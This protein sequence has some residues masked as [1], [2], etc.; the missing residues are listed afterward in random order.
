MGS[1]TRPGLRRTRKFPS[2]SKLA[3]E[4]RRIG[5]LL[6]SSPCPHT[7][8]MRYICSDAVLV[9]ARA[10]IAEKLGYRITDS[11]LWNVQLRLML[12]VYQFSPPKWRWIQGGKR[13]VAIQRAEDMIV[14]RV[15]TRVLRFVWDPHRYELS[16]A[17]GRGRGV[18]QAL[19]ALRRQIETAYTDD[20]FGAHYREA[21]VFVLHADIRHAFEE[22]EHELVME[23]LNLIVADENVLAVVRSYLH[24]VQT[25][26]NRG[27]GQGTYLAPIL[28]DIS[29][30]AIDREIASGRSFATEALPP[31][32][33]GVYTINK[34]PPRLCHEDG[35][36]AAPTSSASLQDTK[37]SLLR[38]NAIG[39][40]S[41]LRC[42][43]S[44]SHSYLRNTSGG[45][46]RQFGRYGPGGAFPTAPTTGTWREE[47]ATTFRCRYLRYGDNLLLIVAIAATE[48]RGTVFDLDR[49]LRQL[50]KN[51]GLAIN[52]NKRHFGL[53][54]DGFDILG[55]HCY[56]KDHELSFRP[57]DEQIDKLYKVIDKKYEN[58]VKDGYPIRGTQTLHRAVKDALTPLC[59][60]YSSA[61]VDIESL[62]DVAIVYESDWFDLQRWEE[63]A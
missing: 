22:T 43:G 55:V 30:D 39:N 1:V 36:R 21:A 9:A 29:F 4:R 50:L 40:Q 17:W 60:Y 38:R 47:G 15:L 6:R 16:F 25:T 19:K 13:K 53:V 63:I 48:G 51:L 34:V 58:L 10:D 7:D 18:H 24:S 23:Q 46:T 44:S 52:R 12:G 5:D 54:K 57:G 42:C 37:G 41:S 3:D 35:A 2:N 8:L 11:R 27:I 56:T 45:Y 59:R 33:G 26:P 31:A 32:G 20:F 14:S 28:A 62:I 49:Q 61:G